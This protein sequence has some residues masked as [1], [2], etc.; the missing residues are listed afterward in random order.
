MSWADLHARG[1]F[2]PLFVHIQNR[3]DLCED[4]SEWSLVIAAFDP[5]NLTKLK[6]NRV[7]DFKEVL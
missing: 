5:Q 6:N 2:S 1:V 3:I 7:S 4:R